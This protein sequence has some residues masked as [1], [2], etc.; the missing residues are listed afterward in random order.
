MPK[1]NLAF[2][3]EAAR[4]NKVEYNGRKV[5]VDIQNLEYELEDVVKC[6]LQLTESDF[7]Q[8]HYYGK[9]QIFDAY[10]CLY[11]KSTNANK[12]NL[13][14]KLRLNDEMLILEIGS[15]HLSS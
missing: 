15:F 11:K 10:Q 14:I 1:Y 13:Y 9:S 6:L 5:Q 3:H 4:L 2:V 12:D 7:H 8:T